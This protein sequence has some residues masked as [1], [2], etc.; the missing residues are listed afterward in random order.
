VV[1]AL[2]VKSNSD[3]LTRSSCPPLPHE[4]QEVGHLLTQ[5]RMDFECLALP[6]SFWLRVQRLPWLGLASSLSIILFRCVM[7]AFD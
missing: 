4:K 2:C 3:W 6:G 7:A 1:G 5:G